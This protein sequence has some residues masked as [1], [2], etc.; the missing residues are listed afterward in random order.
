MPVWCA[1]RRLEERRAGGMTDLARRLADQE[2]LRPG[3]DPKTAADTLWLLTSFDAFD[4]L[5]TGR[6]LATQRVA[7]TLTAIAER[8][9]C[10][11]A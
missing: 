5:H 2:Q 4:L 10:R 9:V 3:V 6:R 7:D 8:A 11:D 1:V